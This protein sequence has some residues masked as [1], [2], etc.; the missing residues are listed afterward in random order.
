[1]QGATLLSANRTGSLHVPSLN[2]F[3]IRNLLEQ[4]MPQCPG[5]IQLAHIVS[6]YLVR[7]YAKN[8]LVCPCTS[9]S[10]GT[11]RSVPLELKGHLSHRMLEP[12]AS[13]LRPSTFAQHEQVARTLV[14]LE[15][16][17]QR[18]SWRVQ[19]LILKGRMWL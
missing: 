11:R 14:S 5:S 7:G 1:M 2:N 8:G 10:V 6:R 3:T 13:C 15:I 9:N 4:F 17:V 12:I 18:P 16:S 19:E